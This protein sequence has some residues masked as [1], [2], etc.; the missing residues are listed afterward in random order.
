[1]TREDETGYDT[2]TDKPAGQKHKKHRQA[3]DQ[4]VCGNEQVS[5]IR[6]LMI[7]WHL[8]LTHKHA[9][10][11]ECDETSAGTHTR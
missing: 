7:K 6:P 1:M 9:G 5:K 10:T 2:K 8:G 3:A 4:T 11:Q